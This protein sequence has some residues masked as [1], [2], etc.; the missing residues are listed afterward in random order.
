MIY[1]QNFNDRG[2]SI[3]KVNKGN[4]DP[5]ELKNYSMIPTEA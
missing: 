1:F 4:H 3:M 5:A 2:E